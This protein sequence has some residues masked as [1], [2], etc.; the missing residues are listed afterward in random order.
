MG[1]LPGDRVWLKC[2]PQHVFPSM[3]QIIPVVYNR[4]LNH[5]FPPEETMPKD[6]KHTFF[7]FNLEVYTAKPA[8]HKKQRHVFTKCRNVSGQQSLQTSV[9]RSQLLILAAAEP[10]DSLEM[11]LRVLGIKTS[12]CNRDCLSCWE[13]Y[14][15]D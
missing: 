1:L 10:P 15:A 8:A 4:T 6:I 14:A 11:H 9:C 5:S 2:S 3:S 13:F 12:P 7:F